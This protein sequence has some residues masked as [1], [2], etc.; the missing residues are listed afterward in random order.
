MDKELQNSQP[1]YSI[2]GSAMNNG[3]FFYSDNYTAKFTMRKDYSY[4]IKT[5]KRVLHRG[6]FKRLGRIPII[7]GFYAMFDG[8]FLFT[9]IIVMNI[10]L[11][12]FIIISRRSSSEGKVPTPVLIALFVVTVPVLL[13]K[14]KKTFFMVRRTWLFHGAEHK[15]IYAYNH[16]VGLELEDV[17]NCPRVS[18]RCGTILVVFMFPIYVLLYFIVPYASARLIL[19]YVLAYELFG[20]E[21]G[22]KLPIIKVFYRF[23]YWCQ[24]KLFTS[25]PTDLHL[26]AAIETLKKLIELESTK[27]SSG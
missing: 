21:N 23:G 8:N 7:K 13:Y 6:F 1:K 4:E 5:D 15:T 20:I 27:V 16:D 10:I 19:A 24:G 25:E 2:G 22:D 26:V 18:N 14:L 11:D 3:I 12:L 9:F 17:R